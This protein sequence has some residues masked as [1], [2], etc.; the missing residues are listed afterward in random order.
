MSSILAAVITGCLTLLGVI[1]TNI[2]GN[3]SLQT[4]LERNQAVTATRLEELTREVREHNNFALRVPV[5]E[6][7]LKSIS[8]RLEN[9]EKK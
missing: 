8:H 9:L 7:K 6:E 2:S 5:M 4:K 1:I 3:R